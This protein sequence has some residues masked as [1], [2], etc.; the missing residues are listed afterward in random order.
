MRE[1]EHAAAST[2][3]RR[4]AALSSLY[5]HLVRHG[6]AA[7][8]PVG[9]VER[10][11]INRDEGSTL[12]FAKAQAR[13][14]LDAPAEDTIAGLRDRA[15]LSVG[16]QVGLPRSEIAALKVGDYIRTAAMIPCGFSVR[17]AAATPWRSTRRPRRGCA[18]I[19][20]PPGTA[21]MS[22]G[23]CSGR[24]GTTASRTRSAD[25]WTPTRSIAWCANTPARSGS[26]A[27]TRRTRCVPPSSP[28]HSKTARSLR[29]CR[30]LLAIAT[31]V[32]RSSMIAAATTRRRQRRFL[33][34]IKS[35]PKARWLNLRAHRGLRRMLT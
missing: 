17:A 21:P 29:T 6:H 18:P 34:R 27:D 9:E 23:R 25:I 30:K 19:S 14:L 8:N 20:T 3:R 31:R 15:I 22:T 10:P 13:K 5:K 28:R 32:Q 1:T 11:A 33:R 26:T 24:C 35:A 4:L 7:T 12:A 2:I 16:L